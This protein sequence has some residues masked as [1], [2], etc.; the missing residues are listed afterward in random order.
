MSGLTLIA[1]YPKSGNTWVRAFLASLKL[2]GG[3][4]DL[5]RDLAQIPSVA[6]RSLHDSVAG[7]ECSDL[8]PQEVARLRPAASRL[9]ARE[10]PGIYKAHDAFLAAPGCPEPAVPADAIAR[11]VYL[12]RDPRD[13]AL[14]A[15]HHFGISVEA[16]A[17]AMRDPEHRLGES[18][19]GLNANVE[20]WLSS[21]SAHVAS[22]TGQGEVPVHVVRYEDLLSHPG[23]WFEAMCR[24]LELGASAAAIER[25]V[26]ATKFQELAALEAG[27]GFLERMPASTRPF[28]GEGRCGAWRDALSPE[29]ARRMGEDHG[30]MMRRFRYLA[31]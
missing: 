11:V 28:F 27:K 2:A 24:F 20:Q 13:V 16:M 29:T 4:P 22:W 5:N 21:W 15:A 23:E 14:S 9:L 6:A 30:E 18:A 8:T 25:S 7:V 26:E 1:S 12:V 3:T 10:R 17:A 19:A 31:D